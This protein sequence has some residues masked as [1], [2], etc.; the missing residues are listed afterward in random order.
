[1]R[2][3]YYYGYFLMSKGFYL[4]DKSNYFSSASLF[5]IFFEL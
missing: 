4:I 1:L 2:E 5:Y 3:G